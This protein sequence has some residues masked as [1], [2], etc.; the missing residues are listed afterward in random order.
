MNKEKLIQYYDDKLKQHE[1]DL[2][3]IRLNERLIANLLMDAKCMI[4]RIIK[5]DFDE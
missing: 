3:D 4:E 2:E 5:G 1:K